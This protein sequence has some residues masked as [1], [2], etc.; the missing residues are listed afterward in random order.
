VHGTL[1]GLDGLPS[2]PLRDVAVSPLLKQAAEPGMVLLKARESRE[3]V[4][5]APHEALG[6]RKQVKRIAVLRVLCGKRF[7]GL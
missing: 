3:C 7:T 2:P 6:H 1:E 5:D 4:R